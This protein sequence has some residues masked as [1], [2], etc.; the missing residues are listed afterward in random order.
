MKNILIIRHDHS[1]GGQIQDRMFWCG[2]IEGENDM[3][4]D[5]GLKHQLIEQALDC[6]MDYK[7]IRIHRKKKGQT[8]VD[9]SIKELIGK[10]C[11]MKGLIQPHE[12]RE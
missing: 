6:G 1:V 8:I 12:G 2:M 4:W 9:S 3:V 5:Y 11:D 7:V 10:P